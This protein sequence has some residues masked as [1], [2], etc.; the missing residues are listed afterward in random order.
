MKR[1]EFIA[2]LAGAAAAWPFIARAQQP[3]LPVVA[4]IHSGTANALA[5]YAAA[6]RK[7]LSEAGYTEGQN[8]T[9]EYHWLEGH[10]ERLAALLADLIRRRVA[11]IATPGGTDAARAVKV[12]TTTIPLVFSVGEDPALGIVPSLARPG[13]NATGINFFSFEV[14]TKRLGLMHELLPRLVVSLSW[15]IQP[16]PSPPRPRQKRLR[17]PL[18]RLGWTSFSSMPPPPMRS[19]PPLPPFRVNDSMPFSSRATASSPAAACSLPRWQ[20]ASGYPRAFL[21]ACWSKPDC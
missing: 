13:G 4:F 21:R 16:P 7:G 19:T 6:F 20:C 2:G 11:A 5:R 14:N 1:R 8:V 10:Y 18:V 12:A 3:E 15:S 9:V 17:R